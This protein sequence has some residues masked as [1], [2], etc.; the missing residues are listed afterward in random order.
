MRRGLLE[1]GYKVVVGISGILFILYKLLTASVKFPPIY[2]YIS[3]IFLSGVAA[4][5]YL[6][7]GTT[8]LSFEIAI[9]LF[10]TLMYGPVVGGFSAMLTILLVWLLKACYFQIRK[11]RPFEKVFMSGLFN[12]GLYAW[13]FYLGGKFFHSTG[14]NW[15]SYI[16]TILVIIGLN[17]LIFVVKEAIDRH[18]LLIYLKE[19]A[20]ISDFLE[21]LIYPIG[22]TLLLLYKKYGFFST[23]PI[24]ITIILLSAIG[25]LYSVINQRLKLNLK[26]EKQLNFVS[27]EV[28]RTSDLISVL[29]IGA[30][31]LANVFSDAILCVIPDEELSEALEHPLCFKNQEIYSR[32][33]SQ[34]ILSEKEKGITKDVIKGEK[35]I[36]TL[37]V[38]VPAKISESE[39]IFLNNLLDLLSI[40]IVKIVSYKASIFD[41]LTGLYSRGYFE[42]RL[43]AEVDNI[44]RNGGKFTLVLFDIDGLKYVNDR[45]GHKSGDELILKFSECLMK[46]TREYDIQARWGGDEFILLIHGV[47][48]PK[49]KEV[50]NRI[51]EKFSAIKLNFGGEE[52]KPSVSFAMT[53]YNKDANI[54]LNELF[55]M[56]DHRL[57]EVKKGRKGKEF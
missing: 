11:E 33:Q 18:N 3:Y 52:F 40:S 44:K 9:F 19:E 41:S 29:K 2:E 30:Q 25:R 28:G 26:L 56:V 15:W 12:S 38:K 50:V 48:E 20:L 35:K 23:L 7:V 55:Q 46:N 17:E 8:V 14:E 45:F 32:S 34:L 1:R 27:Q 31:A 13:I 49:A 47:G 24:L 16:A 4:T 42:E 57:L 22:V 6:S 10:L 53:E 21:L 37:I 43:K 5:L 51:V 39:M 54:E 36:G